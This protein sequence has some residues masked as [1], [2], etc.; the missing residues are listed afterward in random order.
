MIFCVIF[1]LSF[2]FSFFFLLATE[3]D[4]KTCFPAET[5]DFDQQTV[6]GA[7]IRWSKYKTCESKK[8]QQKMQ[9][10]TQILEPLIV[11]HTLTGL[12][13]VKQTL[14]CRYD[15]VSVD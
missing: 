3:K 5:N 2:L 4:E 1:A 13:K 7:S 9:Y 11:G 14:S 12:L 15:G 8:F 10:S 6:C